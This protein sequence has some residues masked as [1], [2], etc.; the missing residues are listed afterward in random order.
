MVDKV[1]IHNFKSIENMELEL[2]LLN[3]FI[4]ANGAGKTNILEALGIISSA[5]YGIVDDESLLRRGVR[6][7]VPRLY[8][9]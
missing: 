7:G 6:P 1:K 8:K 9:T 4:G 2:G 3:I 5:V